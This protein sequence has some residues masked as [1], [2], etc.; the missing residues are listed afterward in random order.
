[1]KPIPAKALLIL[2]AVTLNWLF[3]KELKAATFQGEIVHSRR[4]ANASAVQELF[5]VDF[6]VTVLH[7]KWSISYTINPVKTISKIPKM[8]RDL[9]F[10]GRDFFRIDRAINGFTEW[11]SGYATESDLPFG[12][13][14]QPFDFMLWLAFCAAD[15]IQKRYEAGEQ[16]LPAL[17]GGPVQPMRRF[18]F[19]DLA[20]SGSQRFISSFVQYHD[21]SK[22]TSSLLHTKPGETEKLDSSFLAQAALK[23]EVVEESIIDGTRY[24]KKSTFTTQSFKQGIEGHQIWRKSEAE[25][26]VNHFAITPQV[27]IGQGHSLNMTKA[28]VLDNRFGAMNGRLYYTE[29]G[30]GFIPRNSAD[31]AQVIASKKPVP[32]SETPPA[33]SKGFMS[34]F[35]TLSIVLLAIIPVLVLFVKFLNN[36]WLRKQNPTQ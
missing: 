31:L 10:D 17:V 21:S 11:E 5:H 32:T 26:V 28:R 25:I 35:I 2:M 14:A 36:L 33:K 15:A 9:A 4:S 19:K 8:S 13:G 18:E 7:G 16:Y 6:T 20:N 22:E 34:R 12:P 30:G 29:D 3:V 24:P 23:Y 27:N 1:M